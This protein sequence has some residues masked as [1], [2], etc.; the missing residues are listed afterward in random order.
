MLEKAGLDAVIVETGADIHAEFCI[1][2]LKRNINV[3]TDIP[4]VANLKEA[5]LLWRA[6]E[7]SSAM[8]SVGAN[9]N[10]QKFCIMLQEFYEKGLNKIGWNKYNR[11][12]IEFDKQVICT[13]QD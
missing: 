12:N 2:A 13:K 11:L 9:P 8:I 4:V 6:A 3:L 5:E 1:K 10:E 7:R